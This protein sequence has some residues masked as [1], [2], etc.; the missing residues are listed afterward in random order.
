MAYDHEI[1]ESYPYRVMSLDEGFCDEGKKF[2][3]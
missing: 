1:E 2:M 3:Q